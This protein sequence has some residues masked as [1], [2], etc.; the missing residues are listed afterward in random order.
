MRRAV[1]AARVRAALQ[2]QPG[3]NGG[4]SGDLY[5]FLKVKEHP[6][7]ER[8]EQD[9]HCTIPLNMAQAA[10]GCE[11][12]IPT[13]EGF[14]K[15]KVPEGTQSGSQFRL[16]HKGVTTVTGSGR[17]DLYVHV[18]VRVPTR[19]TRD[20]RSDGAP[21]SATSGRMP[22]IRLRCSEFLLV[23]SST[24]LAGNLEPAN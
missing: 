18:D 3:A 12:E 20:Q 14:H 2:G 22:G 16:R 11:I 23:K 6:F 4:P 13:L 7:F 5:V 15:L 1:A 24:V 19:L 17:G 9:L 10:L 21:T 8:Q